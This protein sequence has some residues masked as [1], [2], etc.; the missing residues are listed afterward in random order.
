MNGAPFYGEKPIVSQIRVLNLML[1]YQT[2]S[3]CGSAVTK[4]WF[5]AKEEP[6]EWKIIK[7]GKLKDGNIVC[8]RNPDKTEELEELGGGW[9]Q[10]HVLERAAYPDINTNLLGGGKKEST[11]ARKERR[12]GRFSLHWPQK[13]CTGM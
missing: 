6:K 4:H 8:L 7:K 12:G 5:K 2:Q 9:Q 3:H 1:K 11:R 13:Q 10:S